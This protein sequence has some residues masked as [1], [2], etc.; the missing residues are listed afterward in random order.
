ML[1]TDQLRSEYGAD[2]TERAKAGAQE[3]W[4]ELA[5]WMERH[6]YRLRQADTGARSCRAITGGTKKSLHAAFLAVAKLAQG[7]F[8]GGP[9][10]F[11]RGGEVQRALDA[12]DVDRSGLRRCAIVRRPRGVYHVR[13]SR[14]RNSR[15]Q[16]HSRERDARAKT[17][18]H[19]DP[20]P[21]A[22]RSVRSAP[23]PFKSAAKASEMRTKCDFY[24]LM[25][26]NR[27]FV[28]RMRG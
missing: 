9:I 1:T 11:L 10:A 5:A 7:C 28:T 27:D 23:V 18:P 14:G 22:F 19:F 21:Y 24:L 16:T 25:E 6:Q 8:D 26:R 12:R 20:I 17:H 2:C 13:R 3:A 4:D 15:Q